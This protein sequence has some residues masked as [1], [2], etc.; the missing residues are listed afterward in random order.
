MRPKVYLAGAIYGTTN[1]EQEWR[2][3]ATE[4]LSGIYDVINPLDRD[5]RGVKFDVVN[6]T[7]LVKEDMLGVDNA[8]VVLANC[9]KPGW[10]TAMEIF[11][12][13]MKGKPVLFFTSN[14]NPSP[15]LF[16]R[17]R[18][19]SSLEEAISELK[20]LQKTIIECIGCN[21]PIKII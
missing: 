7:K 3:V 4:A 17:A 20:K 8:S 14:D 10:G 5:Y 11:Y 18:K 15:W 1:A 12:A 13:H 16:A 21:T 2:K 9:E 6:S 19:T